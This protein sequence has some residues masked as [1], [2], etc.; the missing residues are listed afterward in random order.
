MHYISKSVLILIS[1]K[2]FRVCQFKKCTF[3]NT[4]ANQKSG[5]IQ[6]IGEIVKKRILKSCK[7]FQGSLSAVIPRFREIY[8]KITGQKFRQ[9][10]S[11]VCNVCVR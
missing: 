11:N 4:A 8:G 5:V 10:L 2:L 6:K 3:L 1:H 7:S 9:D